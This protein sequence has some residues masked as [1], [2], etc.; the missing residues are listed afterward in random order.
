MYLYY[1]NLIVSLK[2]C[3][4]VWDFEIHLRYCYTLICESSR[5]WHEEVHGKDA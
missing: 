3:K 1:G 5:P 4:Y 2:S